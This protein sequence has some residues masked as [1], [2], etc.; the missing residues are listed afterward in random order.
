MQKTDIFRNPGKKSRRPFMRP[1]LCAFLAAGLMLMACGQ[2]LA[3]QP[4]GQARKKPLVVYFSQTGHTENVAKEIH[5]L[6][7]GDIIRIEAVK[8]YPDNYQ[9]LTDLAKEEKK[10]MARPELKNEIPKLDEYGVIFLGYPNWWSSMPMPVFAFIEKS[11]MDGKT[12]APFATHGGG[13]LGDS[14]A[15]LKKEIPHAKILKP[16]SIRSSDSAKGDKVEA[17]IKKWLEGLG[18][19][20]IQTTTGNPKIYPDGAY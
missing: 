9:K 4:E 10:Q 5:R 16:L 20:L 18:P 13:G 6:V 7:G 19:A 1:L 8:P 2:L 15:D 12:V 3:A 17:E 11:G 14:M